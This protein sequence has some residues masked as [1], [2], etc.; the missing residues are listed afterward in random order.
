M[1][2]FGQQAAAEFAKDGEGRAGARSFGEGDRE[3]VRNGDCGAGA[4]AMTNIRDTG[5]SWGMLGFFGRCK[6]GPATQRVLA[7]LE[8]C[9]WGWVG[10]MVHTS[11][12]SVAEVTQMV[13]RSKRTSPL[14]SGGEHS[15]DGK[16]LRH[17]SAF[18]VPACRGQRCSVHIGA[19]EGKEVNYLR[20]QVWQ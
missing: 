7:P 16:V 2:F 19:G 15:T 17:G 9:G 4:N 5:E 13:H 20:A 1:E 3:Q 10:L 18:G 12:L 8:C 6:R 11:T 14:E